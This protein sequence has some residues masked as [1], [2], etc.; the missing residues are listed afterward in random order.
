SLRSMRLLVPTSSW[1]RGKWRS[2]QQKTRR[3]CDLIRRSPRRR[4]L[5]AQITHRRGRH[6]DK[7]PFAAD[8]IVSDVAAHHSADPEQPAAL[9]AIHKRTFQ[10]ANQ[11]VL[12]EAESASRLE[13]SVVG[14]EELA[15]LM[16]G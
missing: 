9:A 3:M 5:E 4:R 13:Q 1:E 8:L 11:R 15:H 7:N 16:G 12:V 2:E 10:L 6:V 14:G